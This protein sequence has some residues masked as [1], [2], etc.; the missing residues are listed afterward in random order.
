MVLYIKRMK[1]WLKIF[2]KNRIPNPDVFIGKFYQYLMRKII[3]IL[4]NLFQKIEEERALLCSY[5]AS[6]MLIS[7]PEEDFIQK[8]N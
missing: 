6:I 5:E 7:K 3:P 8:Q 2:A 1:L 4:H